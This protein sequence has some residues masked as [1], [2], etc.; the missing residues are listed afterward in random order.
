MAANNYYNNASNH[1]RPD[2]RP[3]KNHYQPYSSNTPYSS[4]TMDQTF[5][6]SERTLSDP[7]SQYYESSNAPKPPKK[8]PY[9]DSIP[10]KSS[11]KLNTSVQDV[12]GQ[13]TQYPPSPEAHTNS[14]LLRPRRKKKGFF[15][16]KIPWVVYITSLVQITVFIV[17]IIRNCKVP[18]L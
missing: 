4:S 3:S 13:H 8:E 15:A 12:S 10:M 9:S 5:G 18:T 16:G 14:E 11:T 6:S 2:V 7:D 1:Y 17:E